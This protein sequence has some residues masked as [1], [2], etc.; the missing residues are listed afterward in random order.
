MP[1]AYSPFLGD[2]KID[3]CFTLEMTM[4]K[5][6]SYMYNLKKSEFLD[7][8]CFLYPLKFMLCDV[9][10]QANLNLVYGSM[11]QLAS[12]EQHIIIS[13]LICSENGV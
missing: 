11:K 1:T 7:L 4:P 12:S 2:Y 5:C 10:I 8:L 13:D 6:K 9:S 3:K